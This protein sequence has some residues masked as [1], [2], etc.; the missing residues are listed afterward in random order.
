[1]M[2]EKPEAGLLA[3]IRENS[4][5]LEGAIWIAT[6]TDRLTSGL[7]A[8][9]PANDK[10][11]DTKYLLELRIFR[12]D[13]ELLCRRD[14]MGQDFYVRILDDSCGMVFFDEKHFLDQDTS[15][16]KESEDGKAVFHT[17]GGGKYILPVKENITEVC[18]RTYFQA[19]PKNGIEYPVDWRVVKF[20]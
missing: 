9:L 3:Y 15:R 7:F 19:H 11:M 5:I 4:A 13:R 18:V 10:D 8:N 16:L 12:E 20:C 2:M 17:M 14:Y 1:M 6:Y